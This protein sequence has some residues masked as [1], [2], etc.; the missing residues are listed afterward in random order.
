MCKSVIFYFIWYVPNS[1]YPIL[2]TGR[3][4][5]TSQSFLGR[6]IEHL[7]NLLHI[8]YMHGL[9]LALL[10]WH[11]SGLECA[12]SVQSV[13]ILMKKALSIHCFRM[14]FVLKMYTRSGDLIKIKFL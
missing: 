11:Q 7:A 1:T 8:P 6:V 2:G 12:P 10:P 3:Y 14:F 13:L 9:K 4:I 5:S